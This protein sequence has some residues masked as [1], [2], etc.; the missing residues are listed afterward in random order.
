VDSIEDWFLGAYAGRG[1]PALRRRK[2]YIAI[3]LRMNHPAP[4]VPFTVPLI[5]DFPIRA[6]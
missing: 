5:L 3:R 4:N 1:A 6:W 2:E